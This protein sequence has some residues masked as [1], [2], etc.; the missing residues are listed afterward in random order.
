MRF[1]TFFVF[2]LITF[3]SSILAGTLKDNLK[4]H[5]GFLAADSLEGRKAGT[6][7]GRL[8][9]FYIANQF[10]ELG[11]KEING[12]YY[13]KFTY[14][15]TYAQNVIG[16]IEATN[17]KYKDEYIILGAHYDHIGFLIEEGDQYIKP[18]EKTAD[19]KI[20]EMQVYNGADDNA[21]GAAAIIEIARMLVKNKDKLD[22]NVIVVAFD[23]EEDGLY[24]SR[25]FIHNPPVDITKIK[26]MLNLD[27][28]GRLR[29]DGVAFTGFGSMIDGDEFA[30]SIERV[31]GL[32]A[33]FL[34]DSGQWRDRTD[35]GP[36]YRGKI[37]C[38]TV[39]TGVHDQYHKPED[40]IELINFEGLDLIS[41]Q[42]Y[43]LILAMTSK[44]H[45]EFDTTSESA[46]VNL[47][48]YSYGICFDYTKSK[49]QYSEGPFEGKSKIGGAVGL[50]Y[51]TNFSKITGFILESKYRYSRSHSFKGDLELHS[52]EV[53]V[54]FYLGTPK[55]N[56]MPFRFLLFIGTD[57]QYSFAGKLADENIN[58]ADM[59]I[60]QFRASWNVGGRIQINNIYAD[61]YFFNSA[62]SNFFKDKD[63]ELGDIKLNNKIFGFGFSF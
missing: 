8:A 47:D 39:T 7:K 1:I 46:R 40:D 36:F 61:F 3:S 5:V 53:P 18:E 38:V 56:Y 48:S 9:A 44:E 28:V 26:A 29:S 17:P 24:G 12:S 59:G 15:N 41:Q 49:F 43:N 63:E 54:K 10:S 2:S 52:I 31:P 16:L 4:A 13:Q 14:T 33:H 50:F 57:L 19:N 6:A 60:N 30:D 22:R 62:I 20:G 34:N 35:V 21:S 45:F 32:N 23:G 51:N 25:H 42:S 11:L 27:M 37:S 55:F 58:W